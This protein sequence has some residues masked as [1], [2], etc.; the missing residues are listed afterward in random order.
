MGKPKPTL[1]YFREKS[2]RSRSAG[3]ALWM[4]G[5]HIKY[6]ISYD[7]MHSNETGI[8]PTCKFHTSVSFTQRF[9]SLNIIVFLTPPKEKHYQFKYSYFKYA[10]SHRHGV[11]TCFRNQVWSTDWNIADLFR[12]Q[13]Y[14]IYLLNVDRIHRSV[15]QIWREV[16]ALMFCKIS[17]EITNITMQQTLDFL[18]LYKF[19]ILSAACQYSASMKFISKPRISRIKI[20]STQLMMYQIGFIRR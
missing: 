10:S 16:A 2:L 8:A 13:V 3:Q 1:S 7:S 14:F 17:N 6:H 4:Q 19:H 20:E 11:G 15:R 18:P 12:P 5:N 9:I